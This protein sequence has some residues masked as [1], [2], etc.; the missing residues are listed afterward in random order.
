MLHIFVY[1]MLE[2]DCA[3]QQD[4]GL[5]TRPV[6]RWQKTNPLD[7]LYLFLV[8]KSYSSCLQL[9]SCFWGFA[10]V[11]WAGVD[12]SFGTYKF[13]DLQKASRSRCFGALFTAYECGCYCGDVYLLRFSVG[14]TTPFLYWHAMHIT[15]TDSIYRGTG[16]TS[17]YYH[18]QFGCKTGVHCLCW[19]LI[20]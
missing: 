1:R 5:P 12:C 13:H 18:C 20:G 4:P 9:D 10:S 16:S 7:C 6:C 3:C 19:R 14:Q 15:W 8:W 17:K 11:N 2:K